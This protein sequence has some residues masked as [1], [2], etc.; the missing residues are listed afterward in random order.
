[1]AAKKG[2]KKAGGRQKGTPNKVTASVKE[3]FANV[4]HSLQDD[5]QNCLAAWAKKN[6]TDFYKLAS[7]LIPTELTGAGGADLFKAFNGVDT[8]KV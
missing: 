1:L 3:V 7:K 4:F 8:D 6:P 5:E 2:H